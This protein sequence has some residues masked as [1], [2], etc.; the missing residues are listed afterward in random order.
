MNAQ[1]PDF[2]ELT[3][4]MHQELTRLARLRRV[5]RVAFI[6]LMVRPNK[7]AGNNEVKIDVTKI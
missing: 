5:V 7:Y 2:K 3:G 1:T 6:Y 4:R